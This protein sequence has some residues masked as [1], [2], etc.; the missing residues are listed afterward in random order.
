MTIEIPAL[1]DDRGKSQSSAAP[2]RGLDVFFEPRT[3]AVI[4]AT[5]REGTVGRTLVH[6]LLSGPFASRIYPIN[7]KRATILGHQAYPSISE[8][9]GPIDLA[10]IATPAPSVPGVI[11]EC[12]LAG[13]RGA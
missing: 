4:G 1:H 3:V 9:P 13:V 5:E 8:A 11:R 7:P 12:G 10:V 2:R 6:N